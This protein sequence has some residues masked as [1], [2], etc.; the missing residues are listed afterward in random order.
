MKAYKVSSK[1]Q[2]ESL[3]LEAEREL[4]NLRMIENEITDLVAVHGKSWVKGYSW[5]MESESQFLVDKM[6]QDQGR[7]NFR[8]R[9]VCYQTKLNNRVRGAIHVF[10][11][12]FCP[13]YTDRIYVTE[14]I[15]L[16]YNWIKKKYPHSV[17]SEYLT[18]VNWLT[19]LRFQL[20]IIPQKLNHQDLTALSFSDNVLNHILSFDCLEHIPD[21]KCALREIYRTL[22]PKGVL[23]FS[24]PFNTNA[25]K[26]EIRASLDNNSQIIFHSEPEYHG[27][28]MSKKGSLSYYTFGWEVLEDLRGVGFTESFALVYWSE[29]YMYLGG[30]QLLLCAIKK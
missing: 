20:S 24:V 17:G 28:P 27:N 23:L 18:D 8:E 16:L 3:L 9:L 6:Y 12:Q 14:Q 2:F 22:K 30:P 29:K 19:K 25:E 5:P 26:T 13:Q 4:N 15:S 7:P 1:K 11:Q 21:Y 10:E